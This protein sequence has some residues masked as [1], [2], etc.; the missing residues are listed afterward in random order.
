MS[1]GLVARPAA[2]PPLTI[3]VVDD[4]PAMVGALGALLGQAGHRIV[5]A[6]DGEEALRRFTEQ[7]VDLVLLDLAMP[8]VD[9]AAVCRRMRAQADTPIIV[10]SG[11]RDQG[12]PVELLDL[13]ADDY[14][15]KPFRGD[16]LLARIRAVRRR[17]ASALPAAAGAA[18]AGDD[19]W[20][21]DLR[22]HE[23]RWQ[24]AV[25]PATQIEFRLLRA[26]LE[27]RGELV[28]HA[29]L[30]GAGWPDVA[31]PD[32]LWLKPHLARLREKLVRAGARPPVAVRG[33]GYRLDD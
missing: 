15:R 30:L 6:Y 5:A 10:V 31:D 23:I 20:T 12:A 26:L 33:V 3:L 7:Q 28:S 21:L 8:G 4:E 24:G 29:E 32:P 17:R 18:A 19:G 13:G 22:R 9:G 16:E 14:V 25:V 2:E 1:G 11:E 27:R